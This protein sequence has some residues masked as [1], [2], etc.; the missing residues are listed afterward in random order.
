MKTKTLLNPLE[1]NLT[2]W[3]VKIQNG[4]CKIIIIVNLL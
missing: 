3:S 4:Y 1:F 2:F